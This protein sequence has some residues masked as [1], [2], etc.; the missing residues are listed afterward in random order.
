MPLIGQPRCF[1]RGLAPD[2][3]RGRRRRPAGRPA[4]LC[5]GSSHAAGSLFRAG[6]QCAR[7]AL[8]IRPGERGE[9]E[10]G[11]RP[12]RRGRDGKVR[13]WAAGAARPSSVF[14]C[15]DAPVLALLLDADAG[16]GGRLYTG[17]EDRLICA[18]DP[19]V[20]N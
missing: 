9:L 20:A 18:W 13:V 1:S 6:A 12:L 2:S 4:R 19:L 10:I 16:R 14:L 7:C 11:G 3:E 17:A 15:H 5:G 8:E